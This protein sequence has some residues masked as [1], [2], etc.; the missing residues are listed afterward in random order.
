[1]QIVIWKKGFIA[2]CVISLYEDCHLEVGFCRMVCHI[3]V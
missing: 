3:I 2:W 1:M